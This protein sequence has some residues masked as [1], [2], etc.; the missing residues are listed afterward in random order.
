[1]IVG[2]GPERQRLA[3]LARSVGVEERVSFRGVVPQESLADYYSAA[4]V[5]LLCSTREG[6]P[7]VVLE[8]V[9]CGTPVVA[10]DVGG[11]GEV[12]KRREAGMLFAGRSPQDVASCVREVL[13]RSSPQAEVARCADELSWGP[14]VERQFELF[15][16]VAARSRAG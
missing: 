2:D 9:A 5:T 8:S 11:V 14:T 16:A 7:N 4:D 10:A 6:M 1:L 12:L 13:A 15:A 3:Q